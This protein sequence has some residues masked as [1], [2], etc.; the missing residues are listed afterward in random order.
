MISLQNDV[1][2]FLFRF[3]YLFSSFFHL[4][5]LVLL[6]QA[7]LLDASLPFL[8]FLFAIFLGGQSLRFELFQFALSLLILSVF[9]QADAIVAI[10]Y[11]TNGNRTKLFNK[12]VNYIKFM[13]DF[14]SNFNSMRCICFSSNIIITRKFTVLSG[15]EKCCKKWKLICHVIVNFVQTS[16]Q[17]NVRWFVG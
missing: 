14:N 17:I 16:M 6:F 15:V 7:H 4:L 5:S 13:L 1:A 11:C 8:F 2:T 9:D 12:S 10:F 3:G